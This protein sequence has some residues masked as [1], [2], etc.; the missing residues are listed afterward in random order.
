[1]RNVVRPHAEL[2]LPQWHALLDGACS[3]QSLGGAV[4]PDDQPKGVYGV[5][6]FHDRLWKPWFKV[7][8]RGPCTLSVYPY[9]IRRT[10]RTCCVFLHV[11]SDILRLKR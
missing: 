4:D 7:G 11:P 3:L 10:N 1:M 5:L 8:A 6:G 9:R 2:L